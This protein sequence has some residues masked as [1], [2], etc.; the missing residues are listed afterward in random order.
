MK[1]L[2]LRTGMTVL[3]PIL[4]YLVFMLIRFD[5]FSNW[6][7]IY[8]IFLQSIIPTIIAYSYAF[9]YTCGVFDFTLGSRMIISGVVGGLMSSQFGFV[10]MI[11]GALITSIVI[12]AFTGVL[13]KYLR[14]PSL[15]LTMGLTMVYEIVGKQ[16]AGRYGFVRIESQH[17]F[18]G[19]SPQI[20]IVLLITALLF[21]FFLEYTKF[22]FEI[23]AVGSN[24]IISKNSGINTDFAKI[25]AFMY[26]GIFLAI[27]AVLTLSQS[28]SVGAQTGLASATIL[29]KPLISI[30]MA[31]ALKKICGLAVGI[32]IS[33]ISLNIIFVGLIAIGMPDTF[34]NVILGAFLLVV[35]IFFRENS[36]TGARVGAKLKKI[37]ELS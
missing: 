2:V 24:E 4:L 20:V 8:S 5:R 19:R 34:Q 1:K 22:S 6:N 31:V 25:K 27:G 35:M 12:S 28:G 33:Q 9:A 29:F 10:G 36:F 37:G 26:G 32:F 23:K 11:I 17:T 21:H 30:I 15:V 3:L 13:N 14:I 18:L 7:T 16:L